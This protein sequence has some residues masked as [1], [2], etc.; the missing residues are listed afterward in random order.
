MHSDARVIKRASSTKL[1]VYFGHTPGNSGANLLDLCYD[2]TIDIINI[3]FIRSFNGSAGYPT[4]DLVKSC[5]TPSKLATS[6]AAM[7]QCP[8][9]A[10]NISVC[11][12]MGK[13]VLLSIGGSTSNTSFSNATDARNVA[14]TL[15]S[16]FGPYTGQTI[17]RPFGNVT[18]D[19][20]DFGRNF[21]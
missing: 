12:D 19:G 8:E 3:G 17:W 6:G 16:A 20:F 10:K 15:W 4:L 21:G 1:S 7:I 14:R 5:K 9:L 11:Q 13:K 2:S 18:V